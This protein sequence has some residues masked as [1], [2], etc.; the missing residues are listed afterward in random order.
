M[1][2]GLI[3]PIS[4]VPIQGKGIEHVVSNQAILNLLVCLSIA[5]LVL[6]KVATSCHQL[7]AVK[8]YS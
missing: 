3:W 6:D 8:G 2:I 1:G 5:N 4:L 7:G